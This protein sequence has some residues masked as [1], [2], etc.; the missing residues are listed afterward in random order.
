MSYEAIGRLISK[1]D[2]QEI[3][4]K[5]RKREFVIEVP[6][7]ANGEYSDFIKFQL[8]QERCD[9]IDKFKRNTQIKVH[10]NLKGRKWEKDGNTS[11]FN[12]LDVWRVENGEELETVS[13]TSTKKTTPTDDL[14]DLPF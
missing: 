8:T 14:D 3:S 9:L 4:E 12:T 1:D 10:F 11:Y 6:S 7:G 5:F 2:T 13:N